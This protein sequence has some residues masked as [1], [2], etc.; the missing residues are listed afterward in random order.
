MAKEKTPITTPYKLIKI[1]DSADAPEVLEFE[2]L[3]AVK[4]FVLLYEGKKGNSA[5]CFFL[6]IQGDVIPVSAWTPQSHIAYYPD[7]N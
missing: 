5:N 4:A 3:A 2:S 7:T 1:S 6:C